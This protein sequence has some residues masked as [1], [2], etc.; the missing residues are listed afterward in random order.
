MCAPASWLTLDC[1]TGFTLWPLQVAADGTWTVASTVSVAS[2]ATI[3][4]NG[5]FVDNDVIVQTGTL[6]VKA[7]AVS[8]ETT[9]VLT[10]LN[11]QQGTTG[12]N[13][14]EGRVGAGITTGN[15]LQLLQGTTSVFSVGIMLHSTSVVHVWARP[16][17]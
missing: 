16:E 10:A 9:N 3:A 13:A 1:G 17:W 14:I 15:L 12:Q 5:L 11:V 7:G 2:G 6:N 8:V 4:T